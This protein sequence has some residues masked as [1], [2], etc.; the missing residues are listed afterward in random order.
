M[1]TWWRDRVAY[2]IYPRSFQDTDGNGIGDLRGI[3]KRLHYLKELGI[4][5]IWLSPVY[6]SPNDDNGYDI[7]DY[8]SIHPDF[9]TMEEMDKLLELAQKLDIKIIMDLV[10]NHT[11]DEHEWFKQSRD[12]ESPYRDYYIWRPGKDGKKPN[13]WT[14]FFAE[15]CWEYDERSDKY[16]LHLFSKKQPDLNY[17]NPKVIEEIKDIM[18]FW[19]E[20]GVSG[21]RC[22]VINIIFK[23]SL[24][25]GR[26]R[27]ILTGQEHYLTC[28]GTHGILREL[29]RDVLSQFDCFTVGETVMVTPKTAFDLSDPSRGELDMLFSFEH[30]DTDSIIVKWFKK[31][32]K[33][34]KFCEVIAKWQN[35]LDWNANYFEN[36]DQPRSVSRFGDDKNFHAES[37]KMLC[38]LLLCLRGTPFIY[39]GQEIG[40]TNFDFRSM[41]QIR[42]VESLNV[43]RLAT[44]LHIPKSYR[45][46]MILRSGRDNARTPMQ[47]SAGKNAGFTGG[48]PWL[49]INGNHTKINVE[50]Q[51]N[52]PNSVLGFYRKMIRFRN[53]SPLL[54]SGGFRSVEISR[55]LFVFER[56]NNKEKI[57]IVIN[58]SGKPGRY[59]ASGKLLL[60]TYERSDYDGTLGPYEAVLVSGRIGG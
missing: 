6:R 1:K 12:P 60:S 50:A 33:P 44:R 21:F 16:F 25:D 14:S 20:K 38:A 28:E 26:K 23:D 22:D 2:Q 49:D 7:S 39:Q 53:R 40:M 59:N 55:R 37:A 47:W 43:Y 57:T 27:F 11:S 36:H 42:D 17:R 15:D 48:T 34:K 31:R 5:M 3:I 58:F 35:A 46:K 13:N 52:D 4:G 19:L 45:W 9:G 10:I 54:K 8:R 51:E 18:R 41:D 30:M 56:F 29:R 32:F 24:E